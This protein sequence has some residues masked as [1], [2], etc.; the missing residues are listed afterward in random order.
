[1]VL[2]NVWH[3]EP[4]EHSPISNFLILPWLIVEGFTM[5]DNVLGT[6]IYL[7]ILG[8]GSFNFSLFLLW[9]DFLAKHEK[10]LCPTLTQ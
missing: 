2:P 10:L 3:L 4:N 1:M 8:L 6:Q 9:F 7:I 5:Q